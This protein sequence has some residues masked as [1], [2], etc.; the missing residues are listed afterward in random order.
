VDDKPF[1]E[2]VARLAQVRSRREAVGGLVAGALASLGVPALAEAQTQ[3]CPPL[4]KLCE[5]PGFVP[6]CCGLK[7]RCHRKKDNF[8]R[9]RKRH[10]GDNKPGKRM[11]MM[12]S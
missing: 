3:T 11:R 8:F 5:A 10:Y 7:Q 6:R 4:Q 2:L 12:M 1:D 9:C